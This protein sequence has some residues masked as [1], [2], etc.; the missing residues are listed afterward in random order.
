MNQEKERQ[1]REEKKNVQAC[2]LFL[3]HGLFVESGSLAIANWSVS[4]HARSIS[5]DT[6]PQI[7][8]KADFVNAGE[9]GNAVHVRIIFFNDQDDVIDSVNELVFLG[10]LP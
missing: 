2:H 8:T 6:E 9:T 4:K 1:D 10:D 7:F 5:S 3:F